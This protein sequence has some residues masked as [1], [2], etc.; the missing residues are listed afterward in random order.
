MNLPEDLKYT[1]HHEWMRVEGNLAIIGITDYAQE[2][3]TDIVFADLP[4]PG[5]HYDAGAEVC[6]VESVK[7]VAYNHTPI[8]G[9]LAEVN[10]LLK[11]E[12]EKLNQDPYGDAWLFKIKPDEPQQLAEIL[13]AEQYKDFVG[14]LGE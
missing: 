10:E 13:T 8:A 2:K 4:E 6:S 12:P 5:G 7:A 11:T 9:T 1:K 3:L 14:S